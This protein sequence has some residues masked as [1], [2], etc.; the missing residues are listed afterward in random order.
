MA[1]IGSSSEVILGSALGCSGVTTLDLVALQ[2]WTFYLYSLRI[3]KVDPSSSSPPILFP[4][5]LSLPTLE[6][7]STQPCVHA[8]RYA[9][10]DDPRHPTGV[11]IAY[12]HL[13]EDLG[14]GARGSPGGCLPV[15]H[16]EGGG[17]APCFKSGGGGSWDD[18]DG[19]GSGGYG[20]V[21]SS[22]GGDSRCS[23]SV[24]ASRVFGKPTGLSR[25]SGGVAAHERQGGGQERVWAALG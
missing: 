24:T 18:E 22:V 12:R 7:N 21:C 19:G 11:F 2:R 10:A 15:G 5:L 9:A 1:L 6:V 17:G 20:G 23:T 14:E 16:N 3:L 4:C 8:Y 25:V 13:L